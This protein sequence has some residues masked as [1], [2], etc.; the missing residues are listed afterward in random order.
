MGNVNRFTHHIIDGKRGRMQA[1]LVTSSGSS[2]DKPSELA[3]DVISKADPR[4][5]VSGVV[6]T[7]LVLCGGLLVIAERA[8]LTPA[9]ARLGMLALIA[10][11]F[12]L[13]VWRLR[14]A[15]ERIF[16]GHAS[17]TRPSVGGS[18]VAGGGFA[19][20]LL[21]VQPVTAAAMLAEGVGALLGLVTAHILLRRTQ[22]ISSPAVNSAST[23]VLGICIAVAGAAIASAAVDP[24]ATQLSVVAGMRYVVALGM[25]LL[26]IWLSIS[27]GGTRGVAT[28]A[29][30][31]AGI[32]AFG[33]ATILV[34]GGLA[35]G[36]PPLPGLADS[37]TLE[38][39]K[40]A[41]L[42]W[43]LNRPGVM[44][45]FSQW[46]D[47][48]D[49]INARHFLGM[50]TAAAAA[51]VIGTIFG[52][53]LQIRRHRAAATGV[54][55]AILMPIALLAC[56][57]FAIEAAI[58]QFVG[59]SP[60]RPSQ[61]FLDAVAQGLVTVCSAAPANAEEIRAACR[62]QPRDATQLN[63]AQFV[64][65]NEF[66]PGGFIAA[67]GGPSALGII[68]LL[69]AAS[70]SFGVLLAGVWLVARGATLAG[71]ARGLD[72][73]GLASF[74]LGLTRLSAGLACLLLMLG[75]VIPPGF[76]AQPL[77]IAALGLLALELYNLKLHL[78]RPVALASEA[79]PVGNAPKPRRKPKDKKILPV[80]ETV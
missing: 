12:W 25:S 17:V 29:A 63:W 4:P 48:A 36:S 66:L 47:L 19:T 38:A 7:A 9:L 34:W 5:I 24:I 75:V 20:A 65:R 60:H 16:A 33:V 23:T 10:A 71:L 37:V 40:S 2:A 49:V 8:G 73:P 70:M 41:R 11:A 26:L 53:A 80:G 28:S 18:L 64:L 44:P 50:F 14:T 51:F 56:T 76:L 43:G 69:I 13:S 62:I 67:I 46:P 45:E 79:L 32:G 74:R 3:Q 52:P 27:L 59:A 68:T 72:A 55:T 35:L 78:T 31:S 6:L 58:L 15:R 1:N 22:R 30:L 57:G 21:T 77:I 54:L 61:G 39:I 42:N